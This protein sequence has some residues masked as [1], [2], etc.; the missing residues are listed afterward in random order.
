M[1][2]PKCH[3]DNPDTSQFCGHCATILA[4]E[5]QPPVSFTKT[6]ETPA[7]MISE[8]HLIAG[9][10]RILEEIGRGGMG[11]VY[12][13]EDIKLKRSVALKFLPHQWVSDPDARERFIQEA[14]AASALDH[15]NICNIH[16]IGEAEDGRM[17]IAMAFY[18][19]ESLREKI[20]R[21]PIPPEEAMGIV[22]QAATGMA[23]AHQKGIVHRDIKPANI[24]I[25]KDRVVK[26]VDFGLAKL[27]GQVH[28]TR[29]GTTV[30]TV[31]YMSPEQAKG[32]AVDQR[33]DIWSLGVVLYEM[34]SGV[35]PFKG[36]REQ[37]LIHSILQQEPER[38]T[39]L[40]KDLPSDLE[41][42][43]IKALAKV[44]SDRYQSMDEL[45]EDLKRARA[46]LDL[47]TRGRSARIW[48]PLLVASGVLAV[49]IMGYLLAK[50]SLPPRH[51]AAGQRRSI[52]VMYFENLSGD[53]AIDWMQKGVVEMLN[54]GLSRSE[55]LRIL[56]SQRLFEILEEMGKSGSDRIDPKSAA[57]VARR[58]GIET[59][60][61]GNIIKVGPNIRI[62]SK[63][64]DARTGEILLAEQA[65]GT[66]VEDSFAMVASLTKNIRN[67][68]EIKTAA[69]QVDE[70]WL[71]NVTTNS[72]E[73]YRY[74]IEGRDLLYQ[75]KWTEA[76]HLCQ[77]AIAIDPD[78]AVAYIDLAAADW[79]LGDDDSMEDAF[80]NAG[81]LSDKVSAKERLWIEIFRAIT[82]GDYEKATPSLKEFLKFDPENKLSIYLLGRS[83]YF[84]GQTEKAIETWSRL[85]DRGWNWI[86]VYYFLSQAHR[87]LGNYEKAAIVLKKGLQAVPGS[88]IL[89]AE[90]AV[91]A[92]RLG[93]TAGSKRLH[94]RFLAGMKGPSGEEVD[95]FIFAG[96]GY[97]G[98]QMFQE[99]RECFEEG[100]AVFPQ[101]SGIR[102]GLGRA[103]FEL[104]DLPAA[105]EECRQGLKINPKEYEAHYRMG[106]I[107]EKMGAA[108]QAVDELTKY[109]ELQKEG[110]NVEDAKNRLTRI[111]QDSPG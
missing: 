62:Q 51:L 5:G 30:G 18:E 25:T 40:S 82:R 20:E 16:E 106:I 36:D 63:V 59:M 76:R 110:G 103:Y 87:K 27:A 95:T 17:Y 55:E 64:V 72:V 11:V 6:L 39:T 19:G 79:N 37:A 77:K 35:L 91:V 61:L 4:P 74:F 92:F 85:E 29:E 94:Q 33:T 10:Y 26:V 52:A 28:I 46:G 15:Q 109:I 49:L 31:A 67:Y 97:L 84:S 8:D 71:K 3:V 65:N 108:E 111:L 9:K 23:K 21:G 99:A 42:I 54:S 14:R 38:L 75:S 50:K 22:I 69:D 2:C 32:E 80:A 83:Y 45:L 101:D 1:K 48:S 57:E 73:A 58:A 86:W 7:R 43:V 98:D 107:Y 44:P 56:D 12:K 93:D 60:I 96:R 102:V 100:K 13:A 88:A 24:L 53:P 105:L 81:R 66:S 47:K 90:S 70:Q 78:F 41:N 34:I 104:G 89:C 68:L